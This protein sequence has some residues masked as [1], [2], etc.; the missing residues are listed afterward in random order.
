[1][2]RH[3]AIIIGA[4]LNGLT[5]AA[6]LARA[7]ARVLVFE[8]NAMSGGAA[9]NGEL[10]P[11]FQVPR[12]SLGL[13]GLPRKLV[14]DLELHEHGLR[15]LR[16]DGGVT[17]FPDGRHH[18]NYRDG[19]VFRR[20]LARF[21]AR[22]ASAWTR[23]RRDMLKAAASLRPLLAMPMRDP[24]RR[25]VSGFRDLLAFADRMAL[26]DRRAL[27]ELVRLWT[28][29]C[30]EFLD[31]YFESGRVKASLAFAALAGSTL[32]PG[33]PT[34]A[35]FLI[36]P[37]M[38]EI[39][40]AEGGAPAVM[41]PIGGPQA[42]AE[43]LISV[44]RAHGGHVRHEAE[45]TDVL[46]RDRRA[47]GVA[48]ANGE[49]FLARAVISDLDVKRSFLTL[50]AWQ[51]MPEGFIKQVGR[52]RLRGVT[53]KINLALDGAPEFPAVPAGC[54]AL[55]GGLRL[56]LDME[57][58][59]RSF[60]DWRDRVPPLAPL[61]EVLVPTLADRSL[62]P[63]GKHVM[64]VA[65]HGVPEE[66]HDGPW[67]L[68]RKAQFTDLVVTRLAEWSPGLRER[69]VARETLLPADIES[70]VGLTSGDLMQGEL[71]LDQMFFNRP[72]A[73]VAG[74]ATPIRDF[75]LCSASVHPGPL[76]LG[77]AGANAAAVVA[78]ALGKRRAG[79]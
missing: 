10:I 78:E 25:T 63:A 3:D 1:M 40:G 61:I 46:M 73:G 44:I 31:G 64:S 71:T 32:G 51:E 24:T 58:I 53:A 23:Y 26:A 5:A 35:R 8:R 54:P 12:F 65:V 18:A 47:R 33:S 72:M 69:I 59:E 38:E 13:A 28:L 70:E 56:G 22:D 77:G 29:S 52:F 74:H 43:A 37:F 14:A 39:D 7:G 48:L 45:V 68:A 20:E 49:E 27:H 36:G 15:C 76:A 60:D 62:A 19:A 67:T 42:L 21:S 17:L 6:C 57:G 79:P 4:G 34:S 75:Y 2:E 50:F 66:L 9:S 11:G 16:L 41:L 55:R 30:S